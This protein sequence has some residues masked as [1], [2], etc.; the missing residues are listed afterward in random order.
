[1]TGVRSAF[2]KLDT[3]IQGTVRFRDGSMAG[4]E[5]PGTILFKC[6]NGKHQA[7]GG[8]YHIPRLTANVISLGWRKPASRSC[9]TRGVS[10]SRTMDT[11]ISGGCGDSHRRRW[12]GA[13][14]RLNTS[15]KYRPLAFPTEAKYRAAHKLEPVH[16]D[17]CVPITPTTPSAS[18]LFFLLVDDLSRYMWLILLSTKEQAATVFTARAE[19]E[20]GRKLETLRTY[21]GGEF[22]TRTF[23][24]HCPQEGVQRHYT[25]PYTPQQTGVVERCNQEGEAVTT[26]VFILNRSPTQSVDGKTPFEVW[27]G[28][29][30]S[31]HFLHTFGCIAHVKAGGKHPTKLEDR[32]TQMVFVGYEA[33][34]KP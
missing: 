33:G 14:R 10:R 15:T 17:L 25:V 29:K 34:T 26:A 18:M 21:H 30:P 16:G 8:V 2:S 20:A 22:M 3:S 19:V 1:M 13:C 12:C 9:L 11:S 4:I 31:V 5:G 24:K 6:K 23:I 28:V 32:S 7:L 27:H